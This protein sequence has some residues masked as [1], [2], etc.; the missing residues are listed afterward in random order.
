MRLSRAHAVLILVLTA[1]YALPVISFGTPIL[2]RIETSHGRIVNIHHV[3][4]SS[5][6]SINPSRGPSLLRR[7]INATATSTA[8]S[9]L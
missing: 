3:Y 4:T 9:R 8:I 2:S 5:F 1:P 7:C 6:S